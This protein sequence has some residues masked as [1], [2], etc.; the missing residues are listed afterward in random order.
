M[1]ITLGKNGQQVSG[2]KTAQKKEDAKAGP[3]RALGLGCPRGKGALSAATVASLAFLGYTVYQYFQHSG[4]L[5]LGEVKIMGCMN[6]GESELLDLAKIDFRS[7]LLN[8]D[9]QEVSRLLAQHP[10]W[11]KQR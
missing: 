3:K 6:I 7:N 2:P 1:L 11:K 9:L 10:W 8:L 4:Q 5:H